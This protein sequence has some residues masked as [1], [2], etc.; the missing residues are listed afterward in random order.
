MTMDMDPF[1]QLENSRPDIN[2]KCVIYP[3]N[4][5]GGCC[6]NN[7]VYINNYLSVPER[8]QTLQEEFAHHDYTVGD[9]VKEANH[10]DRQQEKLARSIAM[11]R[12]IPLDGLIY[13]YQHELWEPAEIA[14]Y[15]NVTVHYLYNA[16]QNYRNKRGLKFNYNDYNFDLTNGIKISYVPTKHKK[17]D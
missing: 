12:A 6:I 5:W 10:S 4:H 14:D 9:I 16:L 15:F 3:S 1:E 8:Y 13:C 7:D 2:V 17:L 11:E